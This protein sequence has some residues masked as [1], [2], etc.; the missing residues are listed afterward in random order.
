MMRNKHS[1]KLLLGILLAG[2][3][4]GTFYQIETVANAE[5]SSEY[6]EVLPDEYEKYQGVIS[7]YR[8]LRDVGHATDKLSLNV[9]AGSN[10]QLTLVYGLYDIDGNGTDELIVSAETDDRQADYAYTILDLYTL[11]LDHGEII[12]L[13]PDVE[14]IGKTHKL[15]ITED[16]QIQV[17]KDTSGQTEL[18]DK[19]S[20]QDDG[21]NTYP[22]PLEIQ[23]KPQDYLEL[24][25]MTTWVPFV[26]GTTDRL[27]IAEDSPMDPK[28]TEEYPYAV[29]EDVLGEQMH[30]NRKALDTPRELVIYPQDQKVQIKSGD[31][32]VSVYQAMFEAVNSQDIEVLSANN[33][34]KIR[35]IKVN[36]QITLGDL[37]NGEDLHMTGNQWYIFYNKE[38]GISLATPNHEEAVEGDQSQV[39]IEYITD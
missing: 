3:I 13:T 18:V 14:D 36:T 38:E 19:F 17:T 2:C 27:P 33:T 37:I 1:M 28:N 23:E 5:E 7:A 34:E 24:S 9:E 6:V 12:S 15:N 22:V 29:S 21:L 35:P 11:D 8:A 25:D 4:P 20:F 26:E 31:D 10:E 16:G 39:M 30:F 32:E